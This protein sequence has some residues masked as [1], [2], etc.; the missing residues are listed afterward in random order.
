MSKHDFKNKQEFVILGN[1]NLNQGIL[2]T[3]KSKDLSSRLV[4]KRHKHE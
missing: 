2:E 3:L 4:S 1:Q